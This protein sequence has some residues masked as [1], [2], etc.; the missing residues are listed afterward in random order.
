[1][2]IIHIIL[3]K[4][5]PDRMN[6]VNKVVNELATNQN[7]S[8]IDVEVWGITK[9][10]KHDYPTRCYKTVL[11]N[12]KSLIS[13]IDEKL[14]K[15]ISM[16]NKN[17]I[18]HLHGGFIIEMYL[19][20][21]LL[22]KYHLPFLFMPH[23]AY[24]TLA[25][26]KNKFI[27]TIYFQLL[28][29]KILQTAHAIH[30]I[31]KSEMSGLNTVYT[32]NKA[33]LIPYG[34]DV[35]DEIITTNN[36]DLKNK[37]IITYCGR[38]DIKNKGLKELL[39][40]FDLFY[41]INN[42]VQLRIIGDSNER[43][44]LEEYASHL[45]A[46]EN[47]IF[48]GAKFGEEK[49]VLLKNSHVFVLPS[50]NEGLPASV[51][52]AASLGIPSLLTDACNLTEVINNYQSGY[53]ISNTD[54]VLISNGLNYLYDQLVLKNKFNEYSIAAKKMVHKEF[55]WKK[56]LSNLNQVYQHAISC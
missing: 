9:N 5:N 46:K 21:K 41:K 51:L 54:D 14:K 52:E 39:N 48:Y 28:E 36:K 34:Y 30:M 44:I 3:G 22:K 27:K 6:G 24:N 2:K 10:T 32:T 53:I 56:T 25:L 11:F 23:G 42:N 4:A 31:G 13:P 43:T 45:A 1:M 35:L 37:F 50:L 29:K 40:G 7:Q 20:G 26:R 15:A 55:S 16:A 33:V 18:F 12:K 47:I 19:I 8:G 38:L 17:T 49:N